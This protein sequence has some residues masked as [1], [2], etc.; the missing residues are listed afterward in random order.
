[1]NWILFALAVPSGIAVF[2]ADV[3]TA[4]F[5]STK[6]PAEKCKLLGSLQ[7]QSLLALATFT[8]A[9]SSV[10]CCISFFLFLLLETPE[11]AAMVMFVVWNISTVVCDWA[12][13]HARRHVVLAC[14]ATNFVCGLALFVYTGIAFDL[15]A[16]TEKNAL[17]LAAH[18]CNAVGVFHVTIIDIVIWYDSWAASLR[19][20]EPQLIAVWAGEP[21]HAPDIPQ[22]RL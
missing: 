6:P 7:R 14:L 13:L 18:C 8:F 12:L 20:R 10:G 3:F 15:F 16:L 2:V 9:V 4:Y 22:M 5:V 17:V 21:E 11:Y 19:D 1:M